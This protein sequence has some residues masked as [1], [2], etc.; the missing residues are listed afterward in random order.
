MVQYA[1]ANIERRCLQGLRENADAVQEQ[2]RLDRELHRTRRKLH[3]QRRQWRLERKNLVAV[4]ANMQRHIRV[5]FVNT[6]LF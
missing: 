3:H 4:V 1:S 2:L 6:G 5:G